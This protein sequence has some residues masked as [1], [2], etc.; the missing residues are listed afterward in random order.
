MRMNR[1]STKL[2]RQVDLPA[3]TSNVYKLQTTVGGNTR[4][5]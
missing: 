4:G 3:H 2:N 1:L 5:L